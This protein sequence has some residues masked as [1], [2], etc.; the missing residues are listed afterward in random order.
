MNTE[1]KKAIGAIEHDED[2]DR[3]Y[4]PLPGGWEIQ[5]KGKG[6]TFRICE[7]GKDPDRLSVPP[8][9]YLHET[10]ER[11]ARD[12]HAACVSPATPDPSSVDDNLRDR[13]EAFDV[14]WIVALKWAKRDDLLC[15]MDSSEYK[16]GRA[17][18]LG[19][20]LAIKEST[21]ASNKIASDNLVTL[22]NQWKSLHDRLNATL[23]LMKSRLTVLE[24]AEA[25]DKIM[26]LPVAWLINQGNPAGEEIGFVT[27]ETKDRMD[28]GEVQCFRIVPVVNGEK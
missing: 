12:I 2:F 13:S 5:T 25:Y 1:N 3:S 11:M 20:D 7:P 22:E 8:S 10:L 6:S 26:A 15:D 19:D 28:L 24:K 9:P 18:V 4:I 14:G 17:A 21:D 16:S 23:V 27:V